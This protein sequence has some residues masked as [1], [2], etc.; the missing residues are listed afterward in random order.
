MKMQDDPER[1]ATAREEFVWIIGEYFFKQEKEASRSFEL[2]INNMESPA[3]LDGVKSLFELNM[4][5][6]TSF[7]RGTT[8]NDSLAG[9]IML[10]QQYLKAFY[11]HHAPSFNKLPED[12][13]FELLD[14]IKERNDNILSAFEKMLVDR[15]ADRKRKIITLIALILKNIHLKTGAPFNKLPKPAE[16]LIRGI[17]IHTDEVF[18]AS[19]KQVAEIQ[20]DTKIKQVVKTFF[21][22]KQFKDITGTAALFKDELDRYR[23]RT[24]G[25]LK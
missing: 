16:E 25:A 22:V 18:T 15:D 23:K 7:V 20:D 3:F 2:I 19:Q 8:V 6:L 24:L 21:M 14:R 17:F 4:E 13:R 5:D 12:V 1:P 11:P 10:S 9:K